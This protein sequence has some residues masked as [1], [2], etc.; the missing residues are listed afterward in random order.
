M[1]LTAHDN[2]RSMRAKAALFAC[3]LVTLVL[4]FAT[5]GCQSDSPFGSGGD[6]S[7]LYFFPANL[8]DPIKVLRQNDDEVIA[9]LT[10]GSLSKETVT[11]SGD[12]YTRIRL[13]GFS[14][15]VPEGYPEIPSV[16]VIVAVPP[17]K[18]LAFD[19]L[20]RNIADSERLT[21][22][23]AFQ[24]RIS[25]HNGSDLFAEKNTRAYEKVFGSRLVEIEE[26]SY[27]GREKVAVIKFYPVKYDSLRRDLELTTYAKFRFWFRDSMQLTDD[28]APV[29]GTGPSLLDGILLNNE[30]VQT[31]KSSYGAK[32]DLIIAHESLK[33]PLAR[34]IAFKKQR[35]RQ[36]REHY[37]AG[38]TAVD[39]KSIIATEYR[40]GAAPTHTLLVGNI[41]MIPSHRG[42][43]DNT[44]TDYNYQTLDAGSLPDISVG[45]VPAHNAQELNAF[46]DKAIARETQPRNYDDVLLTAGQDTGLGCP[47]NV[48]AVG[49]KFQ[50][51]APSVRLI[52][53]FRSDGASTNDVYSGYNGN[54]NLIVYDG[55]GYQQGMSEIPLLIN[56][57]S[58]LRNTVFPIILD[59]ACLNANWSQ[60]ANARNF[61]EKILLQPGAGA[62]GIMASGGSGNGHE[63]FQSIGQIMGAARRA[64]AS[65]ENNM[66]EIG[67]VI[68]AAKIK[69]GTQ[70]RTFW[71]YYGDPASSVWESPA[72]VSGGDTTVTTSSEVRIALDTGD[73]EA[74][75]FAAADQA[76][77]VSWCSGTK[78][79]CATQT[80]KPMTKARDAAGVAIFKTDSPVRL[81]DGMSVTARA[82]FSGG[83][84]VD[85][86]VKFSR[87]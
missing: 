69:H 73:T 13:P 65:T 10:A 56:N 37:V 5:A 58:S 4:V 60:G 25:L 6:A 50:A 78:A 31:T 75:I 53:K 43:A 21:H 17:G 24:E 30:Q 63:Y 19:I 72:G 39:I 8:A 87:K 76:Q 47:V 2:G 11:L 42:S 66:N 26:Q 64:G 9:T 52:R 45:R 35:G 15:T 18:E 86:E 41:D 22:P 59:I 55:H 74:V 36:V 68:L 32:I 83:R 27:A 51:G 14:S 12:Q 34:L 7:M 80:F 44:W 48:Q 3:T 28:V 46:I 54:P 1:A 33:E 81:Q 82:T 62:A 40:S 70:D 84:V 77:S 57:L 20:E 71:N 49:S 23:V 16:Q 79:A 38:K 85:Q 29:A 61:A 67:Q